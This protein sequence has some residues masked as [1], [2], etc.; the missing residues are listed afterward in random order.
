MILV[1]QMIQGTL[2]LRN[3]EVEWSLMKIESNQEQND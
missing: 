1:C 2:F 3:K